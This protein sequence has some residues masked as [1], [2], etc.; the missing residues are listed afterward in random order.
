MKPFTDE[1]LRAYFLGKL[2]TGE[3]ETLE[4]ECA[5]R[6]DL[7]E[8]AATVE[9]ELIDDYL[10]GNLSEADSRLFAANYPQTETR[11]TRILAA[12]AL[13]K[14]AA[15]K[16]QPGAVPVAV[17]TFWQNLFGEQKSLRFAFGGA[18]FL[19]VCGALAFYLLTLSVGKNDVAE[20]K[21]IDSP[22]KIETSAAPSP[23]N[24]VVQNTEEQNPKPVAADQTDKNK[25]DD[26]NANAPQKNPTVVKTLPSVKDPKRNAPGFAAFLLFSGNVRGEAEQAINIAPSVKKL[27]LLLNPS[28]E[29]NKYK[30]CRAVL[31]TAEGDTVYTSPNLKALNFSISAD[32]LQNRTYIVFLEGRNAAGEFESISEY[33]F[34]VR[35]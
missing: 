9:R 28:D 22:P 25:E 5:A 20:V 12:E 31:K 14:I 27:N 7:T 32:K 29:R 16:R 1:Q 17:K 15:E 23:E 4:E 11:R 6:R 8:Q 35:R 21:V 30:I 2:T 18:L 33:T 10:R 3:S 34:R 19:L 13:W 26:K 24:P